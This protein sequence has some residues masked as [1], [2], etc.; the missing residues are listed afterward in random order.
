MKAEGNFIASNCPEA[1]ESECLNIQ[2]FL[3]QGGG[4]AYNL[5]SVYAYG[6]FRIQGFKK[7]D[8]T[9]KI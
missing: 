5:L 4:G 2:E 6:I 7:I 3:T 8:T 1:G 9:E